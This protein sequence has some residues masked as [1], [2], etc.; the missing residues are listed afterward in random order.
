MSHSLGSWPHECFLLWRR[1]R[2]TASGE[3][4]R[5]LILRRVDFMLP[6]IGVSNGLPNSAFIF[7]SVNSDQICLV[8][9]KDFE[10]F[11]LA[12]N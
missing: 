4:A 5:G 12:G 11:P 2:V 3:A 6:Q 7:E 9:S 10:N 1:S 8:N